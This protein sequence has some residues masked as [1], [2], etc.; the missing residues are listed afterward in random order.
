VL[1]P[2]PRYSRATF[3]RIEPAYSQRWNS[4]ARCKEKLTHDMD[5][6]DLGVA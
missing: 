1:W 4:E 3:R 6:L 5:A 2:L